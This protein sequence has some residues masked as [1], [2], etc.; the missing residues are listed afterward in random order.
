[1]INV[2]LDPCNRYTECIRKK[3][4]QTTID[5]TPEVTLDPC[6]RHRY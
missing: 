1:M 4:A 3:E 2:T 5:L 6:N